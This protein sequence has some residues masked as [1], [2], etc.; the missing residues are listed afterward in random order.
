ML[1]VKKKK[2]IVSSHTIPT[3]GTHQTRKLGI[4]DHLWPA[5]LWRP[6][7]ISHF[8]DVY[9]CC[10]GLSTSCYIYAWLHVV[11]LIICSL[12]ISKISSVQEIIRSYHKKERDNT[13]IRSL[14]FSLV[15]LVLYY[16]MKCRLWTINSFKKKIFEHSVISICVRRFLSVPW[17]H[18]KQWNVIDCE[19]LELQYWKF[20]GKVHGP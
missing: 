19:G 6:S 15:S 14:S 11:E 8:E 16:P 10:Y 17:K 4:G 2:T 5:I 1:I 3:F 18:G 20:S 12:D 9:P 7:L 13:L